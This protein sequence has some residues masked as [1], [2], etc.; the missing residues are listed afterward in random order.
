[1]EFQADMQRELEQRLSKCA[2]LPT[3]SAVAVEVIQRCESDNLDLVSLGK[4]IS[5]DPALSMKVLKM[6]NS[7]LFGLRRETTSLTQALSL[8]GANAVRALVLS[9][10]VIGDATKERLGP[11]AGYWRRSVYSAIAAQEL[12]GSQHPEWKEDAY[13]AGLL[14]DIGILVLARSFPLEYAAIH[15]KNAADHSA[16]IVAEREAFQADHALVGSWLLKRWGIPSRIVMWVEH[17]H[18]S[19]RLSSEAHDIDFVAR[20]VE[21][22]GRIADL[23]IK[24]KPAQ[25]LREAEREAGALF[26]QAAGDLHALI[27]RISD[28]IAA[29][30]PLFE[31]SV[32]KEDLLR[33]MDEARELHAMAVARLE[34]TSDRLR[35]ENSIDSLTG[36]SNR[37]A[38]EKVLTA[39]FQESGE[40]FGVL[41]I[42]IDNFKNVN[43]TYGHSGGDSVLRMVAQRLAAETRV[44]DIVGRFGGEEFVVVASVR[45]EEELLRI[46]ERLRVSISQTACAVGDSDTILATISVGGVVFR[47]GEFASPTELVDAADKALYRAKE[48]GRNRVVITTP[49]SDRDLVSG[50]LGP[51]WLAQTIQ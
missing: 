44:N 2:T 40:P 30:A 45:G 16:L 4:L 25:A 37:P 9:F 3:L 15:S 38:V 8:L 23:W 21:L 33:V 26:G 22:A 39:K 42:D 14:Q 13:L 27:S 17:S 11:L 51:N 43:D 19:R 48:T 29:A 35:L 12:C 36:L 10:S 5:R 6:V 7:P 1:M 20:C 49:S 28:S 34:H 32:S 41:F 24:T 18:D 46:G 47:Y 50:G 31:L